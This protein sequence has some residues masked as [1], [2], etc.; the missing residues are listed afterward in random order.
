MRRLKNKRENFSEA[1]DAYQS[2]IEYEAKNSIKVP[3]DTIDYIK[4]QMDICVQQVPGDSKPSVKKTQKESS[5]GSRETSTTR[6]T[7]AVKQ[8]PYK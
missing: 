4:S 8:K 6:R 3:D 2:F 7:K 1:I 5:S